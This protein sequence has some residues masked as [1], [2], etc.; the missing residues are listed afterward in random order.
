MSVGSTTWR[1]RCC[2]AVP[3]ETVR[4][5][6]PDPPRAV[7]TG[8]Q[9]GEGGRLCGVDVAM[10]RVHS[11][12]WTSCSVQLTNTS[13]SVS[14]DVGNW[15]S[16]LFVGFGNSVSFCLSFIVIFIT[17]MIIIISIALFYLCSILKVSV[18]SIIVMVVIIIVMV[19]IIFIITLIII[20]IIIL[21]IIITIILIIIINVILYWLSPLFL[22]RRHLVGMQISVAN[23]YTAGG[24]SY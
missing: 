12:L 1:R 18:V 13:W 20:I 3:A 15:L 24:D 7:R 11:S 2:S 4:G 10:G 8:R 9:H 16:F 14:S 21:I 6:L 22:S 17:V 5:E 19:F 23:L